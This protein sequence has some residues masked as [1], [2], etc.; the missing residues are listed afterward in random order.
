VK[1]ITV[2]NVKTRKKTLLKNP[3]LV[4][5]KSGKY[6]LKGI[7][8]D[9]NQTVVYRIISEIEAQKIKAEK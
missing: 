7:A 3:Q 9:D 1:E 8:G 5:M 6:A 2:Y 4:T